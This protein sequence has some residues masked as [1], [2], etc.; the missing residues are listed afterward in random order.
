MTTYVKSITF[1]P[2]MGGLR[3]PPDKVDTVVNEALEAIQHGGGK[4]LDIKIALVQMTPGSHSSMYL[5]VY[6]ASQPAT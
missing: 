3:V 2:T 4:I 1:G 5:I 6:D